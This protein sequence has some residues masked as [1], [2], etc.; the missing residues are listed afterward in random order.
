LK[1]Q[2]ASNQWTRPAPHAVG[3]VVP[4]RY[5]A[6]N[7]EMRNDKMLK[8][9]ARAGRIAQIIGIFVGL[10]SIALLFGYPERWL[11]LL[12]SARRRR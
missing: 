10:Q 5:D 2:N 11:P 1:V 7:S 4:G 9:S 8:S 12:I 3:D 6:D